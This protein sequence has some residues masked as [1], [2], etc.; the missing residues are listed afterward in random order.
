[1]PEIIDHGRTGFLHPPQA[2][3]GMA[4]SAI[5]LL[6]D[7]YLHRQVADAALKTVRT[8]FCHEKIVPLYEGY[9]QEILEAGRAG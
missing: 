6:T 7:A 5:A 4:A 1:L 2:L 9:Y 3:D 8:R